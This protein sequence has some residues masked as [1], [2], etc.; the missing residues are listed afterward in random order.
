MPT[1]SVTE[2]PAA[3]RPKEEEA[4]DEVEEDASSRPRVEEVD[5]EGRPIQKPASKKKKQ[6]AR[7]TAS[8][9]QVDLHLKRSVAVRLLQSWLK[10]ALRKDCEPE[11]FH[12]ALDA[13]IAFVSEMDDFVTSNKLTDTR[14][15]STEDRRQRLNRSRLTRARSRSHAICALESARCL[16]ILVP[17]LDSEEESRRAH[18]TAALSK[19]FAAIDDETLC[20]RL[21]K[22]FVCN[23]GQEPNDDAEANKAVDTTTLPSVQIC[24]Y[25]AWLEAILLVAKPELG[26]WAMHQAG[27]IK[28]LMLLASTPHVTNQEA[29][30]EVFCLAASSENASALLAPVVSSGLLP[31]L[32]ESPGADVRSAAASTLTKLGLKAQALGDNSAEATGALNVALSV[33]KNAVASDAASK[34]ASKIKP[35]GITTVSFSHLDTTASAPE[36]KSRDEL[37]LALERKTMASVERAIEVVA[38]LVGKSSIKEEVT[39]GSGRYRSMLAFA[40]RKI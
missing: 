32:L 18:V 34:S 22:P 33:I 1:G 3:A 8:T 14:N 10:V 25:R 9:F 16:D 4:Q 20:K 19:I 39:F 7:N 5:A 27:G 29:A 12:L 30:V 28:E 31:I 24:R 21:L 6:P 13:I 37:S 15:E 36:A 26:L 2:V 38:A 23:Y 40:I 17:L 11:T 35:A